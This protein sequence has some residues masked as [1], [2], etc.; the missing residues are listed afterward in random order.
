LRVLYAF[1]RNLFRNN[2]RD[3]SLQADYRRRTHKLQVDRYLERQHELFDFMCAREQQLETEQQAI[4][5]KLDRYRRDMLLARQDLLV[6]QQ[7]VSQLL[8]DLR[9]ELSQDA[10]NDQRKT[11]LAGHLDDRLDAFYLQFENE[12]R[13][14]E[15][16]IKAQMAE[17][18][19]LVT[20]CTA[21][22]ASQPLLDIGSGRGEWLSLLREQGVQ[23]RGVDLS[24]V[25]A[26]HCHA[27]GLEVTIA[28]GIE[29]LTSLEDSSLGVITAFHVIEHLPFE[30]LYSL[31]EQ[32]HRVLAPGGLL[33]FETPN[34]ENLLV[35]SH[36][37]YH[38]PSHRNPITPTL[39]E[40][41]LRHLGF[42]D[43]AL[44]RLHPYPESARLRGIDPLTE[45]VNGALCGPQDFAIS[46]SKPQ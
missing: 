1:T 3:Y 32:S 28:D 2:M 45:R 29:H 33:L 36:T 46:A 4:L 24:S 35:G 18:L 38:D 5:Q 9:T 6:Q 11:Q 44:Q 19:P 12:C 7:A 37:F 43:T 10:E 21:L 30:Q 23:A 27:Q 39:I 16:A 15:Q 14:D 42:I 13:G 31:V 20:G 41:L 26:G 40:F 25:L 8:G 22:S 34:P 17:Y